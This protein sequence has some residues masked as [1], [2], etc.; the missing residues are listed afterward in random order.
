MDET[1]TY[2]RCVSVSAEQ[3]TLR[4]IAHR[5]MWTPA[6]ARFENLRDCLEDQS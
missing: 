4:Q 6:S 3:Q 2:L 5:V 1:F